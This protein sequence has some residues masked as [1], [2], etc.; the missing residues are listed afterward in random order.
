[1]TKLELKVCKAIKA[2]ADKFGL[3]VETFGGDRPGFSVRVPQSE[4]LV[5]DNEHL[6]LDEIITVERRVLPSGDRVYGLEFYP[7]LKQTSPNDR[8]NPIEDDDGNEIF[9]PTDPYLLSKADDPL[10]IVRDDADPD[11]VFIR[12][13]EY[14]NPIKL[15]AVSTGKLESRII[16]FFDDLN[17]TDIEWMANKIKYSG[18]T[19]EEQFNNEAQSVHD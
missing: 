1:M 13:H 7:N 18:D 8:E 19:L 9:L 4:C 11:D 15:E 14:D 12:C 5:H 6:N 2:M 16:E 10:S 17:R 3:V